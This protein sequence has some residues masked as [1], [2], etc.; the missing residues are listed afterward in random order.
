M[1]RE[2]KKESEQGGDREGFVIRIADSFSADQFQE[3]TGKYVREG[4]VQ[5]DE[6]WSKNWEQA[7]LKSD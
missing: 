5:T 7:K 4:H 2:I 6:H 1:D 3:F